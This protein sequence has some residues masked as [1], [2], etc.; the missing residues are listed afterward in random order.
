[1][2][3]SRKGN[4]I[5]VDLY[6]FRWLSLMCFIYWAQE[7][8]YTSVYLTTETSYVLVSRPCTIPNEDILMTEQTTVRNLS[9][10][11]SVYCMIRAYVIVTY[12]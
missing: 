9:K 10:L 3:Q 4:F 2:C 5:A 8:R 7:C 1:M 12:R 11:Y 6:N